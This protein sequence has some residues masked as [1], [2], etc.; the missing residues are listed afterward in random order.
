MPVPQEGEA[1]LEHLARMGRVKWLV[2]AGLFG[3]LF[4]MFLLAIAIGSVRI[5]LDQVVTILIGSTP[6]KESWDVIVHSVR[7]PRSLTA[8]LAGSAL[9][10]AGLQMQ[11][12]FRNPLADPYVLGISAGAS[13]GVA[14]VVLA[15]GE[16]GSTFISGLGWFSNLGVVAASSL[17]SAL[18]LAIVVLLA[19][20]VR[21]NVTVLIIGLMIG[22]AVFAIVTV[23]LA[24]ADE[25]R[26]QQ[27]IVWGFGSFRGVTW[28]ELQV[29]VP[30]ALLGILLAASTT[31]QLNALL[32]GEGYARSMGLNIRRMRLITMGGAAL[33]A[34]VVTAFTGPIAFLGI[35]TPHIARSL[36][37]TSDHRILVPSVI[38]LGGIVALAAELFAQLPGSTAILPL[39]AATALIGAPV[40]IIVLV[41]SR[42]GAFTS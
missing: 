42:K 18:V 3:L 28:D 14:I 12:L 26:V 19:R 22:Q 24:S 7:L 27:F 17:G 36:L 4:F 29:F 1:A 38:M 5:P 11:T 34:G 40:V 33:L 15:V 8:V 9:G 25:R 30:V 20:H 23:L 32:L 39:N 31:K 41:R 13:L 6:E 37:S 21:N 2:F 10:L 16:R 35:A